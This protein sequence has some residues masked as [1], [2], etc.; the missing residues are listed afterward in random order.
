MN[1]E[2]L[3]DILNAVEISRRMITQRKVLVLEQ[4]VTGTLE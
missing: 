2:K 3:F 1:K 4:E